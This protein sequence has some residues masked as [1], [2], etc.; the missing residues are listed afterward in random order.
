MKFVFNFEV[1][2]LR[3][4]IRANFLDGNQVYRDQTQPVRTQTDEE[5]NA[6]YY[7]PYTLVHRSSKKRDYRPPAKA[8]LSEAQSKFEGVREVM[9]AS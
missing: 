4:R 5:G 1:A 8:N 6:K 9:Q 7:D 3:P 2:H